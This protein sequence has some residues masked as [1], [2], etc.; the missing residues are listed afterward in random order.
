MPPDE[1]QRYITRRD[2]ERWI[3]ITQDRLAEMVGFSVRTVQRAVAAL[4]KSGLIETPRNPHFENEMR[5]CLH[6]LAAKEGN[7]CQTT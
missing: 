2:G 5:V 6:R 1:A 3:A 7:P 4:R